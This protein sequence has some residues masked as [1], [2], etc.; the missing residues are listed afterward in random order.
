MKM[1]PE[2]KKKYLLQQNKFFKNE[3]PDFKGADALKKAFDAE[4]QNLGSGCSRC[5]KN[6]IRR[7]YLI[8]IQRIFEATDPDRNV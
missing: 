4:M 5:K 3:N 2:Q 7:K 6:A 8:K 1:S